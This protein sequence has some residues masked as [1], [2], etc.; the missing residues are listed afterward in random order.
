[1]CHTFLQLWDRTYTYCCQMCVFV[2]ERIVFYFSPLLDFC[3]VLISRRY[4]YKTISI[5][6][7][8]SNC[9][10]NQSTNSNSASHQ[11]NHFDDHIFKTFTWVGYFSRKTIRIFHDACAIIIYPL[12]NQAFSSNTLHNSQPK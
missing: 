3:H 10:L 8:Y 11:I 1:M 4:I 7:L 2:Y 9:R 12:Q 5:Y 6:T